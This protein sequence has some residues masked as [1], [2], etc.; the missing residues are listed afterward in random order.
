MTGGWPMWHPSTRRV[1][2][3]I[4][5]STGLP[6]WLQG[7]G[8][9]WIDDLESNCTASAEQ[10]I[11][12]RQ[13]GFRKGRSCL[14]NL[15]SYDQVTHLVDEEKPVDVAFQDSKA[16]DRLSHRILLEKLAAHGL[17][18]WNRCCIKDD[19]MTKPREW[20][21]IVVHPVSA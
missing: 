15:F 9:L 16:F 10:G 3:G 20:Q 5:R 12:P 21:W 19:R 2:G 7:Q 8:T 11:R 14:T 13:H 6:V 17:E 18:R 4:W 1:T